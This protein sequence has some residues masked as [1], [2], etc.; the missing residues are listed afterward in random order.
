MASELMRSFG[1]LNVREYDF[2][3]GPYLGYPHSY[4]VF[5]DGSVVLVEAGGHTPGSIIAFIT[6]PQGQKLALIGDLTWQQ[7]GVERPTER[8]WISRTMVDFDA[9]RV[10]D[11]VTHVHRIQRLMPELIVVPAHEPR[12]WAKLVR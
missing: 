12:A 10:R 9:A 4:D 5:D 8:P 1:K 11:G 2:P 3:H 7:E 6:D